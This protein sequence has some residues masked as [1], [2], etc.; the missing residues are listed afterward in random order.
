MLKGYF[1]EHIL[2]LK[3]IIVSSH[4]LKYTYKM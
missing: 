2:L 3:E 1:L 4:H